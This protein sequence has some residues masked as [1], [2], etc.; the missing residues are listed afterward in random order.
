[1]NNAIYHGNKNDPEKMVRIGFESE[2]NMLVFSVSDEGPGFD[3]LSLPDPTDPANIDKLSGRGVFL[4]TSLSDS[5]R[6]EQNGQKVYLG[7]NG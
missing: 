4:M 5:I 2:D 3:H 7:F 6:F 1:V